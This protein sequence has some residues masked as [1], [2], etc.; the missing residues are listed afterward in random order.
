MADKMAPEELKDGTKE[1][2]FVRGGQNI[3]PR[4]CGNCIW[5]GFG[6]CGHPT[7]VADPELPRNSEGRVPVDVDDCCDSFQSQKNVL[8]YIVRHGSTTTDTAG[9]HGG[10]QNDPLNAE[11][12]Q[13]AQQARRFMEGKKFREVFCS[14]M[15]RAVQTAKIVAPHI[16][17]ER[18]PQLRPWDVG[19]FTGKDHD[20][21]KKQF[22]V[23]LD[24]PA[25]VIPDGESMAEYAVRMH[26]VLL[27]YIQMAK[28]SGPLLLV[29]HSRNFSQFK[30]QIENENEFDEPEKWDRVKEGGVMTVLDEDP[31]LKVEIVF[32]RGDE[33]DINY[34]S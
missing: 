16:L 1:S 6:S 19:I 10:W 21:Y 11:G 25:R 20:T 17:P 31:E 24:H 12:T 14:D 18:D 15:E 13:Q 26:K 7:V 3:P 2:G 30:K 33:T 9:K 28:E 27:K 22:D 29:C 4:Q 5:M 23:Y 8:L 34:G 32:N